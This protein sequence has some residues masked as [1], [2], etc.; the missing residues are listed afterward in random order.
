MIMAP[1]V[2]LPSVGSL[3]YRGR[4]PAACPAIDQIVNGRTRNS[5]PFLAAD[6]AVCLG[7]KV[8]KLRTRRLS[9]FPAG[10]PE[11]SDGRS[12]YAVSF[13]DSTYTGHDIFEGSVQKP[14]VLHLS[15]CILYPD[16]LLDL[17]DPTPMP[18][19]F[20]RKRSNLLMTRDGEITC[21][22][23]MKDHFV[24]PALDLVGVDEWEARLPA[25][26]DEI[27]EP[28]VYADLICAHF[29]H[30]LVD[31]PA[32]LW[33]RFEPSLQM[34]RSLKLVGFGTHGLGRRIEMRRPKDWP[35][36]I[37]VLLGALEIS[38]HDV[39]LIDRPT[40]CRSLF[41]PKRLSPLFSDFGFS[42]RYNRTMQTIGDVLATSSSPRAQRRIYLSRSKLD[43][44]LRGLLDGQEL[45]IEDMFRQRGFE[46]VHPET[47]S[48]PEQVQAVRGATHIAGCVGSNMHLMVFARNAGKNLF[49]I[50]PSFFNEPV[51]LAI[52]ER[53]GGNYSEFVAEQTKPVGMLRS[54][55]PWRLTPKHQFRLNLQI[56]EWLETSAV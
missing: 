3:G 1:G 35:R 10:S 52:M 4:G 7:T 44:T 2:T 56:D 50:A 9:D 29:G 15:G 45:V 19:P 43:P 21:G 41:V 28:V 14:Y 49:R 31:T 13:E 39:V 34:L 26:M 12:D 47:L 32:R 11:S 5:I 37:K 18:Q 17:P 36:Y 51:D 22:S 8:M 55:A 24:P 25:V 33:Y 27:S 42:G 48:L 40:R 54:A 23:L 38:P 20:I 16:H 30:A 53:S 46:I 6:E